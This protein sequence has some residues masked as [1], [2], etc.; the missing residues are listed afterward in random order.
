MTNDNRNFNRKIKKLR[1]SY[2]KNRLTL[3]LSI[4]SLEAYFLFLRTDVEIL[5]HFLNNLRYLFIL[6]N[7]KKPKA[8]AD[9]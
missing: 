1:K 2:K 4:V 5:T 6:I 9:E 8:Q 7:N 3:F